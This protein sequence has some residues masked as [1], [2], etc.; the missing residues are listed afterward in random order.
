MRCCESRLEEEEVGEE[1]TDAKNCLLKRTDR[2]YNYETLTITGHLRSE[3][4]KKC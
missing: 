1:L 2:V 3:K 4:L